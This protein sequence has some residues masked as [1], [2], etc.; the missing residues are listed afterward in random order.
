[1][2]VGVY[3]SQGGD[4]ICV[5]LDSIVSSQ[6]STLYVATPAYAGFT[7]CSCPLYRV[8]KGNSCDGLSVDVAVYDLVSK[9]II[10][11]S[12]VVG[13][14]TGCYTITEYVGIKNVY[15]FLPGISA[16]VNADPVDDCPTCINP[17]G[18]I[19]CLVDGECLQVALTSGAS[20]CADLGYNDC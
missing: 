5:V 12:K 7:F 18:F 14:D 15:P 11:N 19:N 13:T 17:V 20:T 2:T 6:P 9:P 1:M 8:Y 16:L 4:D 10:P 3:D